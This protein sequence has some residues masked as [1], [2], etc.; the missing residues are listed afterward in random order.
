MILIWKRFNRNDCITY[1]ADTIAHR[2][3]IEEYYPSF[4]FSNSRKGWKVFYRP[5]ESFGPN[6]SL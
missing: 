2:Y 6:E 1:E 4:S 5:Y 3:V